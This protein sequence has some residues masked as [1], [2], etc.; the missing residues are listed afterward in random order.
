MLDNG[1]WL[2]AAGCWSLACDIRIA[3]ENAR[4]GTPD[5]KL[6]TVDCAASILLSHVIPSSTAMEILFTGDPIDA[7]EAQRVG[8]V[9]RIVPPEKLLT[10][11][12]KI[13]TKI[14]EKRINRK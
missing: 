9:S 14:C 3:S 10:E 8:L 12:D 7:R 1:L 6:N 11:A 4:L 2:L 13:A 5:Q